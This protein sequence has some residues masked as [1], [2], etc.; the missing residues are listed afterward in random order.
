MKLKKKCS[1]DYKWGENGRVKILGDKTRLDRI[2]TLMIMI[3][4]DNN[5]IGIY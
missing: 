4:R 3:T 5:G 1:L 2:G